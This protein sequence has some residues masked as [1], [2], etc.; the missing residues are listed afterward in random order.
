MR[1]R[2]ILASQEARLVDG[3]Q[4]E[5]A[6]AKR[7]RGL[8]SQPDEGSRPAIARVGMQTRKPL[9]V[10]AFAKFVLCCQ[11]AFMSSD[12]V[13]GF[14]PSK[15]A[16]TK[17]SFLVEHCGRPMGLRPC[18]TAG[19]KDRPAK[20]IPRKNNEGYVLE[21]TDDIVDAIQWHIEQGYAGPEF[22]FSKHV[23]TV[24]RQL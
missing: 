5:N 11:T 14:T 8:A 18:G 4:Q 7:K 12:L 22:L 2:G 16:R 3:C 17:H 15:G 10:R 9:V 13:I 6:T 23:P 21:L 24:H 1:D 19:T 20:L